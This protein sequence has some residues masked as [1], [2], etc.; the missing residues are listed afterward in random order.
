MQTT[1]DCCLI[2]GQY[3]VVDLELRGVETIP[4]L[5][6]ELIFFSMLD[7][8]TC[9][10]AAYFPK[11]MDFSSGLKLAILHTIYY[12]GYIL[13]SIGQSHQELL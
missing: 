1:Q 8:S 13:T 6:G 12:L 2:S 7:L 4:S 11:R 10:T 5:L 9:Q 3:L